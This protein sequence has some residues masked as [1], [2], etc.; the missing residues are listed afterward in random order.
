MQYLPNDGLYVYFRYD[1]NQTVMCVMNTSDKEKQID[2]KNYDERTS[3]FSKAVDV[4]SGASFNNSFSIP[5]KRMWVL[6][7]KK[8]AN[9]NNIA[10]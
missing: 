3:G 2:F 10:T 7:L 1:N 8:Q 5:A 4:I 6:E 9:E